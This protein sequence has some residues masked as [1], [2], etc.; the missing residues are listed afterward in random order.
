MTVIPGSTP[1]VLERQQSAVVLLE[2]EHAMS[3]ARWYAG[4]TC[5]N[6]EKRVAAE[7]GAREVEHFLPMYSSM[8]RWKDRRVNPGLPLFSRY[9]FLWR[10]VR[11]P[12]GV[13]Q[14]SWR[15]VPV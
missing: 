5:A 2:Q 1:S 14:K 10:A 9:V 3:Q 12:Y 8:R 6:H 7:L 15:G 11:H 13:G 4:Y